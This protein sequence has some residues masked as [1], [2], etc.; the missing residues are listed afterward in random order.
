MVKDIAN[1]ISMFFVRGIFKLSVLTL[2][3]AS[4]VVI[5]SLFAMFIA[6]II[7]EQFVRPL[8]FFIFLVLFAL[9]LENDK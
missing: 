7:G 2:I 6:V 5:A 3:L 9:A 4:F 1:I 8:M